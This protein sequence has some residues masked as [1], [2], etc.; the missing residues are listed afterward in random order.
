MSHLDLDLNN[1]NY[2]EL[3]NL[4]KID[5]NDNRSNVLHKIDKRLKYLVDNNLDEYIQNGITVY[6]TG[7]QVY[8]GEIKRG[9]FVIIGTLFMPSK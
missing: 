2:Y 5:N 8:T 3:L 9:I 6:K 4:F 7:S 1:Y